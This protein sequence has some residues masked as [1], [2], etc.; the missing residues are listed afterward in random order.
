MMIGMPAEQS[1]VMIFV[2]FTR[3]VVMSTIN[4]VGHMH[5]YIAI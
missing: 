5:L 4:Y 1:T 2:G 3:N